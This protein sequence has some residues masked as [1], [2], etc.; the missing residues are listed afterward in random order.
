MILSDI[1]HTLEES[2]PLSKQESW[3][4]SGLQAGRRDKEVKKIFIALDPTEKIVEEAVDCG[5][6]LLLTHHP[7]TLS[8]LK[9]IN[10]DHFSTR[11]FFTAIRNDLCCYA[12]H[13]NYDVVE[14]A[15]LASDRLSLQ[16]QEVL[17]VTGTDDNGVPEGIG[18]IGILS[19]EKTLKELA[20]EV[21]KAFALDSVKVFGNLDSKV[22]KAGLC[23]GSGKSMI[24][25]V[26]QQK[27]DVYI[28]GDIGHHDGLD[29]ME[30]NLSVI[31]AGHYGLEHIF[32][33]QMEQYVNEHFPEVEVVT[34]ELNGPFS[35][36]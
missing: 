21:K 6:D 18:R 14:M 16:E 1:L 29:A 10:T 30:Q 22:K 17:E 34:G 35:V 15:I 8:G 13:T 12:M 25:E 5:A 11:K 33:R 24:G 28:T 4:N 7:M 3:D 27:C 36:L 19:E 31:D 26:L 20:E 32:I 23:P 9:K 2:F